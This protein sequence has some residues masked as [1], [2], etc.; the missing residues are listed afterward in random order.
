[1]TV[2]GSTGVILRALELFRKEVEAGEQ[3]LGPLGFKNMPVI[4]GA[5][6]KPDE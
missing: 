1:M 3:A 2:T 6:S 4:F 5:F